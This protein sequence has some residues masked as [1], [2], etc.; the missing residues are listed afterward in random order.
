MKRLLIICVVALFAVAGCGG[1]DDKSGSRC[2][3]ATSPG[4]AASS[5]GAGGQQLSLEADPQQLKF[6][7]D[8]LTAKAGKVTITMTNQSSL[9]HNVALKG[10]V[11]QHGEVVG[12]G[13]KSTVTADLK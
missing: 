11:D 9:Q 2:Q 13:Q 8:K 12:Q 4:G 5:S 10:G 1:S 7:T 3:T 6:N